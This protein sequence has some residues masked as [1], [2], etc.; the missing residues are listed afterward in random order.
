VCVEP[1][2]SAEPKR[3]TVADD[4]SIHISAN[5]LS[6]WVTNCYV[7]FGWCLCPRRRD[8]AACPVTLAKSSYDLVPMF[9][10][11]P[12]GSAPPQGIKD[13]PRIV[14][15]IQVRGL[16]VASSPC[17]PS[18]IRSGSPRASRQH[19]ARKR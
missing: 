12:S 19:H 7:S 2:G 5:E 10:I 15:L 16:I 11:P 8:F 17:A 6:Q 13:H 14:P 1:L 9:L 18:K 4:I 3:G